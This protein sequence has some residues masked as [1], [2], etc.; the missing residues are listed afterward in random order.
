MSRRGRTPTVRARISRSGDSLGGPIAFGLN[1]PLSVTK[2]YRK[3]LPL[4][5]PAD[6]RIDVERLEQMVKTIQMQGKVISFKHRRKIKAVFDLMPWSDIEQ[7]IR[8]LP[9]EIRRIL[10]RIAED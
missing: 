8:R 3:P 10:R 1:R 2:H 4:A 7:A 9:K 5:H 6:R